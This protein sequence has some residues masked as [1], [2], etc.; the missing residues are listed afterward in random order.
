ML[1]DAPAELRGLQVPPIESLPPI[2][3]SA[4]DEA[5]ELAAMAG[6]ILDPWQQYVLKGALGEREDG[7]WAAFE[8]ALIVSR[9][10]GKGSIIETRELAALYLLGEML[11]LHSAHE[12]KTCAEG[13]RRLL[14]L[15]EN[16]PDL[17]RRVKKVT[18]SHGDEGIELKTGQ[19]IRF[20][21]RT[22]GSGRG[23][24][25]D[26][27]ILDESMI[28]STEAMGA[29][30][31][32]LSACPN[33]QVW[34]TSSAGRAE[35]TQLAR[36]VQRGRAGGDPSLAY[37]EWSIA[38]GDAHDDPQSWAKANPALGI[39]ISLEHIAR[40]QAAMDFTE[41]ARERLGVGTYAVEGGEEWSVI[42]EPVWTGA[43]DLRS[44]LVDPLA[45]AVDVPPDRSSATI[46]VA[47]GRSDGLRHIEIVDHAPGTGWVVERLKS[48]QE[49]WEPKAIGLDAAGPAGSLMT[50]LEQA[51]I[52]PLVIGSR[53]MAQACGAFYDAVA[54]GMLRHRGGVELTAAVRG[55]KK[56]PLGDAWAWS[57]RDTSVNISPL[58]AATVALHAHGANVE[59]QE[60]EG[61]VWFMN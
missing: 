54:S 45:F 33:P 55:A 4:G 59:S 12:F 46:A 27:I 47:G 52:K 61:E 42:T 60:A 48:L 36:V 41:F 37:F 24:S 34:Y 3:S 58:V 57:R 40:E 10:N 8:V 43:T 7:K 26:L 1:L 6:L 51:G 31:P 50:S 23:F 13:F 2:Y 11:T 56:R 35:S 14:F 9:Q 32:T 17:E 20:I 44:E 25:G 30:L 22:S 15:I 5:I 21:A 18:R 28:L 53:E 38:D 39:R 19:R 49:R 16:C 29:L